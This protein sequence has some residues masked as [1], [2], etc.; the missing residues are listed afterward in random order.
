MVLECGED[1]QAII[2]TMPGSYGHGYFSMVFADFL[3]DIKDSPD[4]RKKTQEKG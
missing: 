1:K 2:S 4:G 3:P